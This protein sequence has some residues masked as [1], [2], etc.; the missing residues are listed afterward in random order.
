MTKS[1]IPLV[2]FS[3]L[4]LAACGT[5]SSETSA[6]DEILTLPA[7]TSWPHVVEGVLEVDVEE[8]EVE[9][10]GMSD[11]NIGAVVTPEGVI[12]IEVSARVLR[13][14]GISRDDYSGARVQA[15]LSRP[16]EYSAADQ[17]IYVVTSLERL[18]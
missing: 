15:T 10:D 18:D 16:S 7:S 8:G 11:F 17:T 9:D 5:P 1:S 6:N 4:T 2:L 12:M 13:A 3:C 14:G